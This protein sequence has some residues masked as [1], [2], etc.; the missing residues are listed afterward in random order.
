MT[1]S[2]RLDKKVI[3]DDVNISEVRHP[4]FPFIDKISANFLKRTTH[5]RNTL[6]SSK[7][8]EYLAKFCGH[9]F[10]MGSTHVLMYIQ[11]DGIFWMKIEFLEVKWSLWK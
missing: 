11:A 3:D 6:V 1:F 4:T 7:G 8:L 5:F 9:Y 2:R 10:F